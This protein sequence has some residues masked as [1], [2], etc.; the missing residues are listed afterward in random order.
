MAE[1]ALRGGRPSTVGLIAVEM[2][3]MRELTKAQAEQIK[4]LRRENH[5]LKAQV[6]QLSK[7]PKQCSPR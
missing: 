1:T 3:Q 6:I 2:A 5:A 4:A 7:R